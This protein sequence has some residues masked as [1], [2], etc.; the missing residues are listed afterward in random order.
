MKPAARLLC[1]LLPAIFA[2]YLPSASAAGF[3]CGKAV[4]LLEHA[5]CD[6][7]SLSAKDEQ[8]TALYAPLKKQ[9]IFRELE[10][11]W[12]KDVRN[13]CQTAACLEA[14]YDLQIRQ[15]T[16]QPPRTEVDPNTLRPLPDGQRYREVRDEP[17]PRFSLATL[18]GFDPENTSAQ[19]VDL[20]LHNGVLHALVFLITGT[21]G[22]AMVVE[23]SYLTPLKG[24]L[25]EYS[26]ARGDWYEIARDV[27]FAGWNTS[28]YNDQGERYAGVQDGVFYYRQRTQGN[29]Q[30]A[31]AYTLD[32]RQPPQPSTQ[33]YSALSNTLR[34]A[35][36]RVLGNLNI[37]NNGLKLHYN[38]SAGQGIEE[39]ME[40]DAGGWSLVNPTWSETR[41]VLY[42]DNSGGFACVWR[43]DLANKVLSKIVPEHEAVSAHPLEVN[44]REAVLYI[45]V[46]QLKIA[47]SPAY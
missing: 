2:L 1:A 34:H 22:E 12:L 4:T 31:M 8:L 46:D 45:D 26:D 37:D 11:R 6:T 20:T 27:R 28:T 43:V 7:P 15:L 40:H 39:V 33:L 17:W 14:A 47:L 24:T 32:S 38:R 18:P 3:D 44:G 35:K 5:I 9:K 21:D 13:V 25:L 29:L 10:T 19:L 36:A 30:Q 42:F 16:P 41:P 23:R